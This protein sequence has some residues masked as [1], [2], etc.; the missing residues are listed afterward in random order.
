MK[1]NF[2]MKKKN[3]H[4]FYNTL[5]NKILEKKS[6]RHVFKKCYF[7]DQILSCDIFYL[8]LAIFKRIQYIKKKLTDHV[9]S[10]FSVNCT[11]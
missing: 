3:F 8:Y 1:T 5:L 6:I 7:I 2:L 4:L 9:E 10:L 11:V